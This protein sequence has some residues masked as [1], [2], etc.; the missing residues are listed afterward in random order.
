[1]KVTFLSPITPTDPKRQSVIRSYLSV[2]V[3]AIDSATHS[4][5]IYA[6]TPADISLPYPF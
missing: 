4:V 1:M 3:A 6:D 5:Q 2:T